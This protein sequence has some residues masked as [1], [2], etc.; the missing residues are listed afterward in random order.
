MFYG[1]KL[2]IYVD[3]SQFGQGGLTEIFCAFSWQFVKL[4]AQK[5]K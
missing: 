3:Q 2:T 1:R 4:N 5:I